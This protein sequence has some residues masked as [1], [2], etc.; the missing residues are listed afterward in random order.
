MF[1]DYWLQ[2]D[3]MALN[4]KKHFWIA[5]VHSIIYTIPFL[6]LTRN[7][8]TLSVICITH[9]IIDHTN[10]VQKLNQI[11]NWN[12]KCEQIGYYKNCLPN[13]TISIKNLEYQSIQQTINLAFK[14]ATIEYFNECD[15][16]YYMFKILIEDT[17]IPDNSY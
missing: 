17:T 6:L 13:D 11:K 9:A 5:L 2:N 4:K 3:W 14:N 1:S 10:I 7:W 12:F 16:R 8:L 15:P